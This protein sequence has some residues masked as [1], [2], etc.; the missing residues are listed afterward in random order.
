MSLRP[1]T[2]HPRELGSREQR[3]ERRDAG[4]AKVT[5]AAPQI[6]ARAEAENM[7]SYLCARACVGLWDSRDDLCQKKT[8]QKRALS[9]MVRFV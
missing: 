7:G 4:H 1:Y 5:Q 2:L 9:I 8:R 6:D 3:E